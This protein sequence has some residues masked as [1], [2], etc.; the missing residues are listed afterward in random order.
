MTQQER[1]AKIA[2]MRERLKS[3]PASV[4]IANLGLW[5]TRC[6]EC[7]AEVAWGAEVCETCG[8]QRMDPE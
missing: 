4:Q 6:F 5:M 3:V 2:A 7:N 8:C 1:E